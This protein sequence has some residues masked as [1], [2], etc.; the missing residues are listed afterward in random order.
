MIKSPEEKV[1]M[2]TGIAKDVPSILS[3]SSEPKRL[4]AWAK[5]TISD[6]RVSLT[7]NTF[8]TLECYKFILQAGFL[9]DAE[10]SA[11]IARKLENRAEKYTSKIIVLVRIP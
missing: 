2:L 8:E 7:P 6:K 3:M 11:A 5:H 10:I 4:F 9:T 1:P